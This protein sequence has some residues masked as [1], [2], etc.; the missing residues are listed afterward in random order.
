MSPTRREW[1]RGGALLL[2]ND[3]VKGGQ[4]REEIK[5]E[6]GVEEM[7]RR[8]YKEKKRSGRCSV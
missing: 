4:K 6:N 7:V 8:V 5:I 2:D 1:W 3:R